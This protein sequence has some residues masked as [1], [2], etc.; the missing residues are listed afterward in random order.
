MDPVS[1]VGAA[2]AAAGH[3]IPRIAPSPRSDLELALALAE[4]ADALTMS[5]FRAA[6]LVVDTKPDTTPV[7]EADRAV[8]EMLRTRLAGARPG[9]AILGEEFGTVGRRAPALDRRPDRR[10]AGV[11]ARGSRCGPRCSRWSTA[12]T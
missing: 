5:R 4:E 3:Y 10:Y 11:R 2:A 1:R 6:D 12:T 9:D 7:T 8:E